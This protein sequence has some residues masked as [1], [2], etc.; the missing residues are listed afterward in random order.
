[1]TIYQLP[2]PTQKELFDV[3][4]LAIQLID[5]NRI[6]NV[7]DGQG[8]PFHYLRDRDRLQDCYKKDEIID[9]E[10]YLDIVYDCLC[11]AQGDLPSSYKRPEEEICKG[12]KEAKGLRMWAFSVQHDDFL[13]KVYTKFCIRENSAGGRYIHIDCH[14]KP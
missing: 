9:E 6:D 5:E 10:I 7:Y 2:E 3:L 11:F 13:R 8:I 4:E 12:H 1:M 14:T